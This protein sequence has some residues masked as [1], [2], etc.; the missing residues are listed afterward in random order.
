GCYG[1]YKRIDK[2][3]Y[4]FGGGSGR[5]VAGDDL[6]DR[7]ADDDAVGGPGGGADLIGSGD[8]EADADGEAGAA[9]P[10]GG[11][12]LVEVAGEGRTDAGNSFPG[13]VVEK[14]FGAFRDPAHAVDGSRRRNQSDVAQAA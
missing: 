7:A 1:F 13:N 5:S 11:D 10:D 4:I 2:F 9:V 3:L 12:P 6:D 8:A 14:P